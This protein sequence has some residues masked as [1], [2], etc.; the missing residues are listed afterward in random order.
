MCMS[1][2]MCQV[3][4][5]CFEAHRCIEAK[6]MPSTMWLGRKSCPVSWGQPYGAGFTLHAHK[7]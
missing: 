2:N 7:G 6:S 4:V 1:R 5:E 3:A